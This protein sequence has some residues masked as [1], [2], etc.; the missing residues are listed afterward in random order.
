LKLFS[1]NASSFTLDENI[2]NFLK[3]KEAITLDFGTSAY[4]N[5]DLV[6][7]ILQE[8][9]SSSQSSTLHLSNEK[10][11]LVA[12]FNA[13]IS[14]LADERKKLVD[15][16]AQLSSQLRVHANDIAALTAQASAASRTVQTL[17][18][19]NMRLQSV[20]KNAPTPQSL[21][22]NGVIKQ[23]YER[24]QK[25]FQTLKAQNVEAITSLKVLEDEN[26][27]LREEVE[28]LRNQAKN[29]VA[30]KAG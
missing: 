11:R 1:F 16:N 19:E 4:I 23:A 25:E 30:P 12:Q 5:S 17:R 28:M 26:D 10:E 20:T 27:E 9:I 24:L 2:E 14:I 13:Q 22:S 18:D 15:Q 29:A 21:S 7:A 3:S 8:L 6:P